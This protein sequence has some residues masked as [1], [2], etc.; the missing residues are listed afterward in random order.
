MFGIAKFMNINP[1]RANT[2]TAKPPMQGDIRDILGNLFMLIH[3]DI[4]SWEG[5]GGK[6]RLGSG[7]CR[8]QIFDLT[9][10]G[11]KGLAHLKPIIVVVSDIPESKMSVYKRPPKTLP[12]SIGHHH[13]WIKAC[14]EGTSTR[15]NFDFAGP[16]TE[17]LCLGVISVRLGG[18]KLYWDSAN[19]RVTNSQ[20][21]NELLQYAY[22]TGWTL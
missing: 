7:K 8:L 13:E 10:G 14:K 6:L 15:S 18:K 9:A 3:D 2:I 22:R 16:L 4:C 20:E 17:S 1:P 19:M 21:A 12:R 5:F 11:K